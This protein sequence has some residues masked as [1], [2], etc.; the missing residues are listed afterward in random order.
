MKS[1]YNKII[2]LVACTLLMVVEGNAQVIVID[3]GHGYASDGSNPDGRTDTEIATAL[4]V[5]LKLKSKIE[6]RCSGWTAHMTRSTR[7]G[8]ISLSQR[9]TMSNSWGADRFISIHCNAGG[10]TGT[11]TFWGRRSNAAKQSNVD[12]SGEIQDRMVEMGEW[13]DRRS[14]EDY[15]YLGYH[16]GVLSGNNA[17][18]VLNE[19]GFVDHENDKPKLLSDSWRDIFADAYLKALE[20]DLGSP[21]TGGGGS[22]GGDTTAPTTSVSAQGGYHSGDFRAT[23]SDNDNKGIGQ[24]FYRVLEKY[25]DQ[26]YTNRRNGFFNDDCDVL[27]SQYIENS[28]EWSTSWGTLRQTSSS[29]SNT[30]L[31]T[32]LV[33][34]GSQPYLYQFDARSLYSSGTRK[35]GMHIMASDPD[36]DQRGNSYLVWFYGGSDQVIIYET[37][38]NSLYT[39][40][41]RTFDM[42][43][44]LTNYKIV[45]D[46]S[47]GLIEVFCGNKLIASWRDSSPLRSGNYISLRTNSTEAEFDNIG[48]YKYRSGSSVTITAGSED[49][50]NDIRTSS[51]RVESAVR[52]LSGNWGYSPT[53]LDV[54]IRTLKRSALESEDVLDDAFSVFPN[55]ASGDQLKLS[56][57]ASAL[58]PAQV[59]L[60]NLQGKLLNSL[61]DRPAALGQRTVDVSS[62]VNGL[63]GG[64]YFI[65]VIH[66]D[67][68]FQSTLIL[69]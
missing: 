53:P 58:Q 7:N 52:D 44:G 33:Q 35:F 17:P 5:G 65:R 14:A 26:W 59:Y 27:Y 8:W 62:L 18:G 23:F 51:G 57:R 11:E 1:I 34:N 28:G 56:Y 46:P 47:S 20:N 45:Y 68:Q 25:G 49:K 40:V 43:N 21:C 19:I 13:R 36:L 37:I 32:Y 31:S 64:S 3:P 48:V 30:N 54:S 12:F 6:N 39:R 63:K 66:G 67:R 42:P 16:L 2:V 60:Y 41:T 55:P 15:S 69:R 24:R 9:R 50:Y 61:T 10:G 4:A 38:N 22:T 29:N